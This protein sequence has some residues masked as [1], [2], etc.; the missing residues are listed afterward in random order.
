MQTVRD[1]QLACVACV[2]LYLPPLLF[3][4]QKMPAEAHERSGRGFAFTARK[5]LAGSRAEI[6]VKLGHRGIALVRVARQAAAEHG[7]QSFR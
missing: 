1:A 5:R 3:A 2:N 4:L 7:V 6:A